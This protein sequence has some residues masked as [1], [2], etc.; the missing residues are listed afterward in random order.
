MANGPSRDLPSHDLHVTPAVLIPAGELSWRFSRSRGPGGQNVNTTDSR[1]DLV[2][3]L[4]G[5]QALP[6]RLK[7]RALTQLAPRLVD[8]SVVIT[9]RD[10]RSQW[11]NRVLAQ[12]RLVA[13]LQEALRAPPPPRRP[14][15]RT[16]GSVERRLAAKKRR[17]AIKA[18]R[19]GRPPLSEG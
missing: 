12:R 18:Q 13:L 6:E 3:D 8:G 7:V 4:M 19:G 10:H 16:R 2:F 14:T 9:A 1:V 15:R 5:S 11:R 17:S